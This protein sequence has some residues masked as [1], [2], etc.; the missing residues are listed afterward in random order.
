MEYNDVV[1]KLNELIE[2]IKIAEEKADKEP[3]IKIEDENMDYTEQY[4][5]TEEITKAN[6]NTP[7]KLKEEF[8]KT[9]EDSL[10]QFETEKSKLEKEIEDKISNTEDYNSIY[11]VGEL[12][13]KVS[14]LT[15][16]INNIKEI[17]DKENE[18]E[19]LVGIKKE[20]I[21]EELAKLEVRKQELEKEIESKT[22]EN[23]Y[24]GQYMLG[25]LQAELHDINKQIAILKSGNFTKQQ[26][27]R[28]IV[29]IDKLKQEKSQLENKINSIDENDVN[30]IYLSGEQHNQLDKVNAKLKR[31][32]VF[33]AD[34]E[35]RNDQEQ[36][37]KIEK[38]KPVEKP[39]E[40]P[41]NITSQLKVVYNRESNKY[42]LVD[43]IRKY[44]QEFTLNQNLLKKK[45]IAE[46]VD[47]IEDERGKEFTFEISNMI[48]ANL[49][50]CLLEYD[51]VA[52]TNRAGEY[53]E[54]LDGNGKSNLDVTYNLKG[55]R[56]LGIINNFR[57][58]RMAKRSEDFIGAKV[59]RNENAITKAI[60]D[61]FKRVKT[62]SL[63]S[64]E[65]QPVHDNGIKDV[66][67]QEIPSK[68]L[69]EKEAFS[70][71]IKVNQYSNPEIASYVN[72]Y[73][74]RGEQTEEKDI[75]ATNKAEYLQ[76][77]R[78]E[79]LSENEI[80]EIS[81]KIEMQESKSNQTQGMSR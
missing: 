1:K 79:G 35:K 18:R 32:S 52:G 27:D 46:L 16:Q 23:D 38:P 53:I 56:T 13:T 77:L 68:D 34:I 20:I 12:Q 15:E 25:N 4:L 30:G 7:E 80:T 57:Q 62:K 49:Y 3:E 29:E 26:I 59:E 36:A 10:K 50:N 24:M 78:E 67:G 64:P 73:M 76:Q 41:I 21:A 69:D 58:N 75:N 6:A 44:K 47:R 74:T 71:R 51:K 81:E 39:I 61:L 60:K 8:D 37:K 42:E 72:A 14:T 22:D 5:K 19:E 31:L 2:K 45:N 55:K 66:N 9:V 28:A 63:L 70:S 17:S 43:E 33:N 48:D 65:Q 40:Q 11:L 54:S